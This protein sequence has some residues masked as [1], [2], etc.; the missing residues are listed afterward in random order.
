MINR[1]E[2][3]KDIDDHFQTILISNQIN[4]LLI[5][6]EI[7]SEYKINLYQHVH[8]VNQ[9]NELCNEYWQAMNK[10][11]LKL[12]DMKLKNCQI[13]DNVLF[14]K[15][16]L[17]MLKQMHTKLL[18][19]IHDQSSILHSDIK[20]MIDLVQCFYYW[21]DHQVTIQQYIWNCHVY[22]RSKA[23]QDD[24]NDLL[25]PLSISQQRWQ[26]IAMNFI[27]ELSLSKNYNI[28]CI[29]IYHLFKERHYVLC[30]W[31]DNDISI[32]E[33]VWIMLW[34]VYQLHDLFSF[35]IS[36]KDFQFILIMWQSLCKRLKIKVNLL[37]V[38]HS[39]IDDQSEQANQ[40]VERELQIYCNYMQN[41]WAK[42]LSMM[43]FSDNFNT[44]L[45]ISMISFYFNKDF[46][47]RMSF[48]SDMTDYEMTRQCIKARKIDDIVIWMSEFLIFDHQQ[49]KK[50]KQINEAQINKHRRDIIYEVDDQ[51]W[52]VFENIKITKSCKDL[53]NKQL[54]LYSIT[55]KVEIFYRLQLFKSMKHIHSMFSLKYLWSSSN[56]LLLKQHSESFKLMII[57]ENEKH[58]KVD[59]ILN[60]RQYREK[61]QYKIKWIEINRDDEWYY[62]NKEEFNDLK[63]V[64]NEF[65]KLYLNKLH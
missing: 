25:Q 15:N 31:E 8:L 47:S 39:E 43:K 63:K 41:D 13:I 58:W 24:T 2:S 40:D 14:K 62:V 64:L 27:T 44:F 32:E 54:D 37:T 45:T 65:H 4:V 17:W 36:N 60:F 49:L 16:L 51:V 9:K 1:S 18:W 35:I 23:S 6:F 21:S 53:K 22:Q 3:A 42:W 48:D 28:I 19:K 57:E 55:V 5:E 29:I 46:H 52:L 59:D 30:H 50:I 20:W 10:S 61:L 26:D 34:N 11:E 38:Y 7:E 56:N 33:T 12:H